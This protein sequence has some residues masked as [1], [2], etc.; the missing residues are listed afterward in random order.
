MNA[1]SDQALTIAVAADCFLPNVRMEL[2]EDF[3]KFDF[4]EFGLGDSKPVQIA[5]VFYSHPADYRAALKAYSTD[6]PRWFKSPIPRKPQY[7][8]SFWYHDIFNVPDE[9]DLLRHNAK[10]ILSIS[11][12]VVNMWMMV[13]G[14]F[15]NMIGDMLVF[16]QME[17]IWAFYLMIINQAF[18][19]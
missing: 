1:S 3:L 19:V 10:A 9:N 7:E 11:G 4:P 15:Q 16:G 18:R 5:L 8:G 6:F 13:K 12:Y 17:N 14:R 2:S